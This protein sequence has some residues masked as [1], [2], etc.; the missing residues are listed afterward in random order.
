MARLNHAWFVGTRF[1]ASD[2][3]ETK[4]VATN[5]T[6]AVFE[7]NHV[8]YTLVSESQLQGCKGC[9]ADWR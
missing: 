4:F 6:D 5:L 3:Q 1:I 7:G 8:L 2:L 9:R